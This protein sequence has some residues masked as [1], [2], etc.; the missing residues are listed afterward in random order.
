VSAGDAST[1]MLQFV[2]SR[3]GRVLSWS[4][5]RYFH[6]TLEGVEHLPLAGPA[7]LVGNHAPFGIDSIVLTALI[8]RATGRYIRFVGER[9]LWKLPGLGTFF[10]LVGALPSEHDVVCGALAEGEWVGVYP[11]G[12]DESLKP[13]AQRHRLQWGERT[14]FARIAL[15]AQVP[16][17]PIAGLGIDETYHFLLRERALGRSFLGSARYDIALGV[18]AFGTPLPRRA[19][20]R[21]IVCPPVLPSGDPRSTSD[22]WQV[23][24][25]VYGALERELSRARTAHRSGSPSTGAHSDVR[26]PAP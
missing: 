16:I 9:E 11:G 18:G 12:I 15:R 6:A 3:R 22:V 21:F 14:G 8:T 24:C 17:V 13:R 25:H 19:R 7:L 26:A 20:H 2:R 4:L 1:R 5:R 23:R 10:D